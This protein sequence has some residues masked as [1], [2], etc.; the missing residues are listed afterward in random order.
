MKLQHLLLYTLLVIPFAI[1]RAHDGDSELVVIK[2]TQFRESPSN[3]GK[4]IYILYPTITIKTKINT[5]NI[6]SGWTKVDS[7]I[8][9]IKNEHEICN[10]AVGFIPSDALAPFDRRLFKDFSLPM[11]IK[12]IN[13]N[14]EPNLNY[15]FEKD[16]T[17][18]HYDPNCGNGDGK[19]GK[20]KLYRIHNLIW[21]EPL[22]GD[23]IYKFFINE[24]GQI[25][26]PYPIELN[27]FPCSE[28]SIS[29]NN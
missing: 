18:Y 9:S 26:A 23:F 27:K 8:C 15:V 29:D 10:S 6:P 19:C 3:N 13:I 17:F 11:Q 25:C 22:S 16:G 5:K 1:L 12:F 28:E 20:S 4:L 7:G 2:N 21:G 24:K 14:S